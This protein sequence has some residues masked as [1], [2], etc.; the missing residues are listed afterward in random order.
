[1][2]RSARRIIANSWAVNC[3]RWCAAVVSAVLVT[4]AS[5]AVA[6]AA[7]VATD[8]AS[9]VHL[10]RATAGYL[11]PQIHWLD[12]AA[13]SDD[14]W[15]GLIQGQPQQL[16]FPLAG[17]SLVQ[18]TLSLAGTSDGAPI[19][20][21]SVPTWGAFGAMSPTGEQ[22]YPL[23]GEP[24]V[25]IAQATASPYELRVTLRDLVVKFPSGAQVTPAVVVADAEQLSDETDV[26][27]VAAAGGTVT[28]LT[29]LTAQEA[30]PQQQGAAAHPAVHPL[31]C[32][33]EGTPTLRCTGVADAGAQLLLA[34]GTTEV[35]T[36]LQAAGSPNAL[37]FG[38]LLGVPNATV[39][40]DDSVGFAVSGSAAG[41]AP[42]ASEM[43][44]VTFGEP[45][46]DML[47]APGEM[48]RVMATGDTS[49][50]RFGI[51][52]AACAA[53]QL[54]ATAPAGVRRSPLPATVD[55]QAGK[56]ATAGAW[57]VSQP[58]GSAFID[59]AVTIAAAPLATPN[60]VAATSDTPLP[61]GE[62]PKTTGVVVAGIDPRATRL[63]LTITPPGFFDSARQDTGQEP[64]TVA[65]RRTVNGWQQTGNAAELFQV[66]V[67]SQTAPSDTPPDSSPTGSTPPT[68]PAA[69]E[70]LL[71]EFV[72]DAWT[73]LDRAAATVRVAVDP[74]DQP[75]EGLAD[76]PLPAART[77][78]SAAKVVL[79]TAV[80]SARPLQAPQQTPI[81]RLPITASARNA[82][83]AAIV[84]ANPQLPA[85]VTFTVDDDGAVQVHYPDGTAQ[86]FTGHQTTQQRPLPIPVIDPVPQYGATTVAV[87]TVGTQPLQAGDVVTVAVGT[88]RYHTTIPD[89]SPSMPIVVTVDPLQELMPVEVAI[90]R[91]NESVTGSPVVV[92]PEAL[93]HLRI[94]PPPHMGAHQVTVVADPQT[95]LRL[96]DEILLDIGHN[97]YRH[98]II[99]ADIDTGAVTFAVAP[100]AAGSVLQPAIRRIG[101]LPQPGIPATI[102]TIAPP[103]PRI[104]TRPRVGTD[105]LMI[106]SAGRQHF[107]VG[108]RIDL[109]VGS[110]VISHQ[111]NAEEAA[112]GFIDIALDHPMSNGIV[113]YATA[114]RDGAP[115]QRGN[116]VGVP[117]AIPDMLATPRIVNPAHPALTMLQV[118]TSGQPFNPGDTLT[119]YTGNYR[120]QHTVRAT[121][122]ADN[123][124]Q[125]YLPVALVVGDTIIV[126]NSRPQRTTTT[127]HPVTVVPTPANPPADPANPVPT[128]PPPP[129]PDSYPPRQPIQ[130]DPQ[131]AAH[132][133]TGVGVVTGD[134]FAEIALLLSV[135]L[136]VTIGHWLATIPSNNDRL[137]LP[138]QHCGAA[139]QEALPAPVIPPVPPV[140]SAFWSTVTYW[141]GVCTPR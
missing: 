25:G 122:A 109:T 22:Q 89:D 126:E 14:E 59:C 6:P 87:H 66:Q 44:T 19:T 120:Y 98:E 104:I 88:S 40:W 43:F 92:A 97:H 2:K 49:A 105:R 54:D 68:A 13:F 64:V 118:T 65:L 106:T 42:V 115:P 17:G 61:T 3:R 24:A 79:N 80:D 125:I 124:A 112:S 71:L 96:H 27:T 55:P 93:A 116:Q 34:S 50:S 132:S 69:A 48:V 73:S 62:H 83:I 94:D 72:G 30:D 114:Y 46:A 82:I 63:T 8:T 51:P 131:P 127:S 130:P 11:A 81:D 29:V 57:L 113:A 21:Q 15:A 37:A 75:A 7:V 111:V 85:D 5:P 86:Y 136:L 47:P 45:A 35:T 23:V 56:D 84:A 28:R 67:S 110:R 135:P 121:E 102:S 78:D 38:L 133:S 95:P 18:A 90:S 58:A 60:L 77:V 32:S 139:S 74:A 12:F 53:V 4:T 117:L 52:T 119:V 16:S 123:L 140:M 128:S 26:V 141:S 134:T 91:G 99:Q 70:T 76:A 39:Q 36:T 108:D 138:P 103:S 10:E 107:E 41:S 129:T 101:R 9:L 1:M 20:A 100:L 31:A 137:Q 33:G